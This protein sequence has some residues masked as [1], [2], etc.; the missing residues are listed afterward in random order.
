MFI[1][2][3]LLMYEPSVVECCS[4]NLQRRSYSSTVRTKRFKIRMRFLH[5]KLTP[6]FTGMF[7]CT[8]HITHITIT[9]RGLYYS[10]YY[11]ISREVRS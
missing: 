6:E 8:T 7:L 4:S 5:Q 10:Y 1:I 9:D 2:M 11:S 3:K